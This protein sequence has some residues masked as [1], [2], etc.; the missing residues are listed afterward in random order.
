MEKVK[1]IIM[2]IYLLLKK[3][4]SVWV[5]T[6]NIDGNYYNVYIVLYI[7]YIDFITESLQ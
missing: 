7:T 1:S 4:D 2:I 3:D 5:W 6:D